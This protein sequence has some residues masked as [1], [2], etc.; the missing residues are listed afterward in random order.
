MSKLK[1]CRQEEKEEAKQAGTGEDRCRPS[2]YN[3]E[4]TVAV[5][6]MTSRF[7]L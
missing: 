2:A 6:L 4:T 7:I 1:V 3:K 5:S